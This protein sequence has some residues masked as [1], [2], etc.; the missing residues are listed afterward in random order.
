MLHETKKLLMSLKL[1]LLNGLLLLL[2]LILTCLHLSNSSY[3]L[4][5]LTSLVLPHALKYN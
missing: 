3:C 2:E 1:L 5:H 4:L